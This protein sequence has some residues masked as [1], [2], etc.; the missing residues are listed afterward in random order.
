MAHIRQILANLSISISEF[1]KSP[2]SVI[3]AVKTEPIAV[4]DNNKPAFYCVPADILETLYQKFYELNELQNIQ[5]LN[6]NVE[7]DTV[8]PTD[9]D[10]SSFGV[11][12]IFQSIEDEQD[13]KLQQP[14]DLVDPIN[15][16][17]ADPLDEE[18]ANQLNNSI[19]KHLLDNSPRMPNCANTAT[20]SSNGNTSDL[21]NIDSLDDFSD[22]ESLGTLRGFNSLDPLHQGAIDHDLQYLQTDT[23]DMPDGSPTEH[24]AEHQASEL[25]SNPQEDPLFSS[26]EQAPQE[27]P[28]ALAGHSIPL[29]PNDTELTVNK[30]SLPPEG[31]AG[32]DPTDPIASSCDPNKCLE[33]RA[34]LREAMRDVNQELHDTSNLRSLVSGPHSFS[35]EH[36]AKTYSPYQQKKIQAKLKKERKAKSK[37]EKQENGHDL[38]NELQEVVAKLTP[39]QAAP[40]PLIGKDKESKKGAKASKKA[41]APKESNKDSSSSK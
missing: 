25:T 17:V 27:E 33:D 2:K 16:H 20:S 7:H 37:E 21:N 22:L 18:V 14:E 36:V 6:S 11:N 23:M 29:A 34:A 15:N 9:D 8:T 38:K 26:A 5:D 13:A 19:D 3:K 24:P 39:R 1:K 10:D 31:F 28:K 40:T 35:L 4:I 12:D 30:K 41:K 32:A